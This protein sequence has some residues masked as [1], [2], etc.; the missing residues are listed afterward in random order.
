M[1]RNY[2]RGR[3]EPRPYSGEGIDEQRIAGA[4]K[5]GHGAPCPYGVGVSGCGHGV[6]SVADG[7]RGV[8]NDLGRSVGISA[9]D[10]GVDAGELRG[11]EGE[12][13]GAASGDAVLG[14][15]DKEIG[16]EVVEALESVEVVGTADE[17]GS[18]VGG[19]AVLLRGG[20]VF[21]TETKLLIEDGFAAM[22]AA[23]VEMRATSG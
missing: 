14:K 2:N 17:F 19:V 7:T 5:S 18:E 21:S 3:G 6:N 4:G 8:E 9:V 11:D 16:K 20:E 12:D 15:K 13:G 10:G 22:A 23:G 1:L